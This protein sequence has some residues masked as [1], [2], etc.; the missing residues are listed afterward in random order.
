MNRW[1][2]PVAMTTTKGKNIL[3]NPYISYLKAI[4][5]QDFTRVIRR[6]RYVFSYPS[7]LMF[8][9]LKKS[10]TKFKQGTPV[11]RRWLRLYVMTVRQGCSS[12]YHIVHGS[13]FT[14]W[15]SGTRFKH[16]WLFTEFFDW[17][18]NNSLPKFWGSTTQ[19]Y[20]SLCIHWFN[21][22][23]SISVIKHIRG[24]LRQI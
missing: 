2:H 13:H 8:A 22:I 18:T 15:I 20:S 6:P 1:Q 10:N 23:I 3:A 16:P 5:T 7:W 19:V 21:W 11:Y 14:C 4:H 9:Y 24:N 12:N 17:E